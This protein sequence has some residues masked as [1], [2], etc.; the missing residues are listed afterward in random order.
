MR[1]QREHPLFLA[2]LLILAAASWVILIWQSSMMKS[3]GMCKLQQQE[4]S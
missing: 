2:L 4:G 1:L 3:M